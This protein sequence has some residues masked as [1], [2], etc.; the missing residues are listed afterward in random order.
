MPVKLL[1]DH[2]CQEC[3]TR[4][5]SWNIKARL[6]AL[7][8]SPVLIYASVKCRERKRGRMKEK[9]WKRWRAT[10]SEKEKQWKRQ[11]ENEREWKR[12]S[13]R[14]RERMQE[15]EREADLGRER[16]YQSDKSSVDQEG[17]AP[18]NVH[19]LHLCASC[20][21]IWQGHLAAHKGPSVPVDCTLLSQGSSLTGHTQT[22]THT[23]RHT[24]LGEFCW[25]Q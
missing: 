16:P 20:S 22:H 11:K 19:S 9:E 15:C 12:E 10:E 17:M 6:P 18:N 25:R 24:R 4:R 8:P 1:I 23:C 3:S 2:I 13:A 21:S 14:E 7:T 5:P